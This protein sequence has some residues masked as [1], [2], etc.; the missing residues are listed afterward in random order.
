MADKSMINQESVI[1]LV[2]KSEG[3][4]NI[5]IMN[6][7]GKIGHSLR[8]KPSDTIAAVKAKIV[9]FDE[10]LMFNET[11]LLDGA[12]LAVYNIVNGSALMVPSKMMEIYVV[13]FTGKRISLSVKPTH[14]I[15][16]VKSM[17]YRKEG[18]PC[19][20]QAL[21]F[22]KVVLGDQ[23]YNGSLTE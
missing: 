18:I 13:S 3:F 5:F 17:V 20:T 21:I 19:D 6:P 1:E 2:R 14:T 8:V 11:V 15:F 7:D 23:G 4:I 10:V 9:G 22:K 12:T 16:A